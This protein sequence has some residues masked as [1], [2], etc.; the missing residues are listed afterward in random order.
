MII[1]LF[2]SSEAFTTVLTEERRKIVG[3]EMIVEMLC[4]FALEATFMTQM[5]V[6]VNFIHYLI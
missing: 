4:S 3:L 5:G 2:Y 1:I 6:I